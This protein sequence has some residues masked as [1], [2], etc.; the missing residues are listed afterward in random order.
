[1]F[2]SKTSLKGWK[3]FDGAIEIFGICLKNFLKGMETHLHSPLGS[4]YHTSKTS[5]KGWKLH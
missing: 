4:F 1:M 2:S 3:L 5:L